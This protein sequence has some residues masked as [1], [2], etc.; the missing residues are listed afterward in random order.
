[1]KRYIKSAVI[2]G[3]NV[4]DFDYGEIID[5]ANT[6]RD[7]DIIADLATCD[8]PFL[9][10]LVVQNPNT[11]EALLDSLSDDPDRIVRMWV[12]LHTKNPDVV[13]KL[14]YDLDPGVRKVIAMRYTLPEDILHRLLK[15]DDPEVRKGANATLHTWEQRWK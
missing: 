3:L 11:P 10:G 13:L 6:T 12:A 7:Q 2:P 5:I 14:S 1:M 9:R 4:G 15:D 8:N